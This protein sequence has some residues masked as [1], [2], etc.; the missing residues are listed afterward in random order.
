MLS[1]IYLT[2]AIGA[3]ASIA[4]AAALEPRYKT[5]DYACPPNTIGPMCCN[6]PINLP[7]AGIKNSCTPREFYP[8]ATLVRFRR[9]A[10]APV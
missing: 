1:P 9:M 8:H 5:S 7:P 6:G 10:L 2:A 4:N 3:L